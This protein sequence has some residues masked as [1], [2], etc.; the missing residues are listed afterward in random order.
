MLANGVF[1][2]NT[3]KEFPEIAVLLKKAMAARGLLP[4]EQAATR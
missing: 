3:K 4:A 2:S 1:V